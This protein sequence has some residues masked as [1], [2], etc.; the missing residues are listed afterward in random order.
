MFANHSTLDFQGRQFFEENKSV[1]GGGVCALW[2]KLRFHTLAMNI[3]ATSG[4]VGQSP[5]A[6]HGTIFT[7]NNASRGGGGL[8]IYNSTLRCN[9]TMLF[10]RNAAV[11]PGGGIHALYSSLKFYSNTAIFLVNSALQGGGMDV[12]RAVI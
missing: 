7:A 4:S 6:P 11:G 1:Y 8:L 3:V 10:V 9:S 5:T 12:Y 2:C